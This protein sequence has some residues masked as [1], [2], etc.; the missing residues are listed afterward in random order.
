MH[1]SPR[2]L[3]WAR[4]LFAAALACAALTGAA[5]AQTATAPQVAAPA[6]AVII[7]YHRFGENDIPSTNIRLEQFDAHIAELKRGNFNVVPVAEIAEAL[8]TGRPLP[9]RTIAITID[10]GYTTS[11]TEAWPRVKAAGFPLTIFISTDNIDAKTPRY[12]TWDQLREMVRGGVTIGAHTASHPHMP[13]LTLEQALRDIQKGQQRIQQELGVT[14]TLFAYPFGEMSI[15]ARDAV[16]QLGYVAAFGQHSGVAE[17]GLDLFFQPR[18]SLNEDFGGQ[19]RFAL[20]VNAQAFGARD[21]TPEDPILRG[22]NPP[23]FGFTVA[24]GVRFLEQINCFASHESAP[25]RI[26]RLDRR[27]EVRAATPFP[28][29]RGRFNGTVRGDGDRWRWFG[30]QFYIPA[31]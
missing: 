15:A 31:R 8:R 9:D 21:V 5:G 22:N 20:I 24:E 10:D 14:P 1:R 19:A 28:P 25:A 7:N 26:E 17:P 16:K 23:P 3:G 4:G 29:G 30:T 18:F 6:G 13:D 11:F 2:S 27:I 12:L